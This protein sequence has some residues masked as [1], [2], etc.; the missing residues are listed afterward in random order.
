MTGLTIFWVDEGI[1]TGPILLQKETPIGPDDT[2]GSLY[3]DRLFPMGVEAMVETVRLVREGRAPRI[4]QD[5]AQAT[6]EPPAD[7]TTSA[8]D[9]SQRARDVYNL[10]RGSNPQPGAHARLRGDMVRIFDARMS[11]E[12]H[13][14]VPGTVL[15][16]GDDGIDIALAG[17]VLHAKRLQPPG[18]KKLPAGEFASAV[19]VAVGDR[20]ENG[21]A[22]SGS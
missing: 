7:D 12:T 11:I 4:A 20:F 1:D 8:I 21:V 19:G 3:F 5:E 13:N 14:A 10:V 15:A 22:T 2:V 18:G 17:G 16:A 6:Y 9:W